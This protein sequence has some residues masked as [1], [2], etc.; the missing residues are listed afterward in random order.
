VTPGEAGGATC[1][2]V[3]QLGDTGRV[4]K[5]Q[6]ARADAEAATLHATCAELLNL[7]KADLQRGR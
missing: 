3:R 4:T 6:L 2:A 7:Q 5:A 1:A